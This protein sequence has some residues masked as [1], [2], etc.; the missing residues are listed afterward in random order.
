MNFTFWDEQWREN[1]EQEGKQGGETPC[2]THS[3]S[4]GNPNQKRQQQ[5]HSKTKTQK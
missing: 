2:S 5:I 3:S 1:T 4:N